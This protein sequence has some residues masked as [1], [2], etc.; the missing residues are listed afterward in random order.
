MCLCPIFAALTSE[1][2]AGQR[3]TAPPPLGM[4]RPAQVAPRGRLCLL[5]SRQAVRQLFLVQPY[6]GSNPSSPAIFY[7]YCNPIKSD[8]H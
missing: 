2:M 8:Y 7:V 1:K 4:V 5:G 3:L 6:E